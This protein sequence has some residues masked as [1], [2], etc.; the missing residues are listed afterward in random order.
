MK[1]LVVNNR[2]RHIK[3]ILKEFKKVKVID[4]KKLEDVDYKGYDGIILSGGYPLPVKYHKKEYS[5]EI[6]LI[7]KF[8]KPILGVCLGFELINFAYGERLIK[9]K[10]KE[11]GIIQIKLCSDDKLFRSFPKNFKVYEAHR[12]VVPK[13]K[14]L[15]SL[16]M[17]KDG[18]EAVRHPEKEIYGVQFHPEVFVRKGHSRRIFKNFIEI[19][20]SKK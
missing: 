9:L 5:E 17:S 8:K 13:N 19:V 18:V 11:R 16:A 4:F 6:K 7:K 12:W 14:N 3:K 15:K 1:L 10:T 2:S 20:K